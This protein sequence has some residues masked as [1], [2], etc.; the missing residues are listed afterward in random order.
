[1]RILVTGANGHLGQN[2]LRELL[3]RGHAVRASVRSL[4]DPEKTKS[5]ASSGVE[6]V[7]AD[8]DRPKSVRAAMEGIDVVCHAAAV[9][10][11]IADGRENEILKASIEGVD[12]AMRAAKDA[13]VKKVVLTSS[14][15]TLPL[16]KPGAAPVTEDDWASD[17]RAP[18]IRAKTEGERRGWELSS[19]LGLPLVSILPGAFGGPGFDRNTPTIDLVQS[20]LAGNLAFGAP[21]I[22]YPYCD[23]RDIARAHAL[24]VE[25]DCHGRFIACNDHSPM[26]AEIARAMKAIDPSVAVPLW[27]I[28]GPVLGFAHWLEW[29]YSKITG[30]PR[31]VA[32][33][34]MATVRGLRWNCSN[35]RAEKVLGWRPQIPLRQSLA[36]TIAAI[37]AGAKARAA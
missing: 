2:L 11:I 15:V 30:V 1:M 19:A 26:L 16:T 35:G 7:E 32:P 9:Y 33:E 3:S 10:A 29:G 37:K 22:N 24:A 14:V 34:M 6:L 8:L 12:V 13:G 23:V 21:D 31:T 36:D 5:I 25:A 27:T 17:L 20:I 18:Y 4:K 28:P